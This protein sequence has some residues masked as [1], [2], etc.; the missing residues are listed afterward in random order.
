MARLSATRCC[1]LCAARVRGAVLRAAER[2]VYTRA[3]ARP[4]CRR[5]LPCAQHAQIVARARRASAH[6]HA[7]RHQRSYVAA[8]RNAHDNELWRP[9]R[10]AAFMP[11]RR[12]PAFALQDDTD[13]RAVRSP[14]SS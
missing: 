12:R 11:S 14:N 10:A 6:E 4:P 1:R 3:R 2:A 5:L 7:A 8:K 9:S 13:W